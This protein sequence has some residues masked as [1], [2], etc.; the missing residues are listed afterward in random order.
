MKIHTIEITTAQIDACRRTTRRRIHRGIHGPRTMKLATLL[1]TLAAL[2]LAAATEREIVAATLILEAGVDGVAG[3]EA[4]NEV[5]HNRARFRRQS[6]TAVCLA[7]RQ[8][9]AWNGRRIEAGVALAKRSTL[10]RE[11]LAIVA[12]EPTKHV[13][14]AT[15]YW[16][17]ERKADPWGFKV[18]AVVGGHTFCVGK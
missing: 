2:P 17:H 7:R 18:L 4:V 5:I 6:L 13:A 10:W 12:A 8:F 11:A 9:S 1:L 15:H 16:A 14:G 3:L